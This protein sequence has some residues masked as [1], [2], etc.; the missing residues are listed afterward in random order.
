MKDF[1]GEEIYSAPS[2]TLVDVEEI[3]P[4]S[5]RYYFTGVL[6]GPLAVIPSFIVL[7]LGFAL[8]DGDLRDFYKDLKDVF[9]FSVI[10]VIIAYGACLTY[11]SLVLWGLY[12]LN[13][14]SFLTLHSLSLIPAILIGGANNEIRIFLAVAYFSLTCC[15]LCWYAGFRKFKNYTHN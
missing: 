4:V 3:Q 13:K 9:F 5:L 15:L 1:D 2:S 14:L 11:G 8:G 6:L 7:A 12:K 10:G